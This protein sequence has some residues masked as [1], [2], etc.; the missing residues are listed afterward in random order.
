MN[1]TRTAADDLFNVDA[2]DADI[3]PEVMV[4]RD[5]VEQGRPDAYKLLVGLPATISIGSDSYAAVVVSATPKT[6]TAA[7]ANRDGNGAPKVF[8]FTKS[9]WS[10]RS[11]HISI[12]QARD[13]RDPSF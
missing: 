11:H 7:Y 5:A 10:H 2:T 9:G 4:A 13:Y 3:A 6:I 8:R 12:G 1:T